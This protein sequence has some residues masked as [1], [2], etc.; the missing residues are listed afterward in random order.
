[1]H[2]FQRTVHPELLVTCAHRF[3]ERSHYRLSASIITAGHSLVFRSGPLVITEIRAGL[4]HELP[5]QARL[6]SRPLDARCCDEIVIGGVATWRSEFR[7]ECMT[8]GAFL[9]IQQQL[10]EQQEFEGL[11]HRFG[12]PPGKP[13]GGVSYVNFQAF[14]RHVVV[15]AFH[16]FPES[17]TV[18][19]TESR[20][21]LVAP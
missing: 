14:A 1:M 19:R 6:L 16:T 15:R 11:L 9:A 2:L 17:L 8:A 10:H 4:N 13:F 20:F 12:A 21:G 7:V 3:F 18:A 5:R